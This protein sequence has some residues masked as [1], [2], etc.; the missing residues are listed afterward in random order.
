MGV[1]VGASGIVVP[2][3][4]SGVGETIMVELSAYMVLFVTFSVW[5]VMGNGELLGAVNSPCRLGAGVLAVSKYALEPIVAA[6]T[7]ISMIITFGLFSWLLIGCTQL[8]IL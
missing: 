2:A 7:A 8:D 4:T 3:G 6:S 1:G 5:L